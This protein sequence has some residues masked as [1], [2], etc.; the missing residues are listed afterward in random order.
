MENEKGNTMLKRILNLSFYIELK[1]TYLIL[2]QWYM[3][4]IL[5]HMLS[6]TSGVSISADLG[7]A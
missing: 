7:D 2:H 1:F 5:K 6:L 4:D 3:E